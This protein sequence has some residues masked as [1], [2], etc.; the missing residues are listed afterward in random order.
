VTLKAGGRT[1]TRFIL[2]GEAQKRI[3]KIGE[4]SRREP[5][6]H[7]HVR[8]AE[9]KLR[10]E[11]GGVFEGENMVRRVLV[12]DDDADVLELVAEIVRA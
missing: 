12:V 7:E 5:C 9:S 8:L 2:L 1:G 3:P 11:T 6:S 10:Q 4:F